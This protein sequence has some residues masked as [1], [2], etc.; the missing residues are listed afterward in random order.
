MSEGVPGVKPVELDPRCWG[1]E[2]PLTP[3]TN[4]WRNPKNAMQT[5]LSGA[6]AGVVSTTQMYASVNEMPRGVGT[7]DLATSWL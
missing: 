2:R 3:P 4:R 6:E 1:S 5:G 7:Q